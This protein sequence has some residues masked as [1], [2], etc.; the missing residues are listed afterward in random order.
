MPT[1]AV[2]G[3]S[4]SVAVVHAVCDTSITRRNPLGQLGGSGRKILKSMLDK[5]CSCELQDGSSWLT[6]GYGY[7][8]SPNSDELYFFW[9]VTDSVRVYISSVHEHLDTEMHIL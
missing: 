3:M 2:E 8:Q 5:S 6:Y 7:E 4:L 9:H 1:A